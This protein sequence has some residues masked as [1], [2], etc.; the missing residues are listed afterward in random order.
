MRNTKGLETAKEVAARYGVAPRTV[1][2]W[3]K[4]GTIP[5]AIRI[6]S[7]LRFDPDAVAD[8]LAEITERM[9]GTGKGGAR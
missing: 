9:L 8:A 6:G 3:A 2:K 1:L 4:N 7:V 5:V